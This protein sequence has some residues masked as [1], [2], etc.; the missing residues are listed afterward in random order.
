[1]GCHMIYLLFCVE[2]YR[3][4]FPLMKASPYLFFSWPL[5]YSCNWCFKSEKK[6]NKI[7]WLILTKTPISKFYRLQNRL[8]WQTRK[9][10]HSLCALKK[11]TVPCSYRKWVVNDC[12]CVTMNQ[13]YLSLL[14]CDVHVSIEAGKD[15]PV[16][17]ARVQLDDH[18]SAW[19]L[20][21]LREKIIIIIFF[22]LIFSKASTKIA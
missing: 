6:S 13:P 10:F 16:V 1:M 14:E 22:F 18:R 11:Y 12:N 15:T 9:I 2:I 21:I 4:L 7:G 17:Y 3:T 20:Y 19:K 5:M 8:T